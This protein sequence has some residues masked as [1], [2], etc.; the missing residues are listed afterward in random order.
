ML[1]K[2][3]TRFSGFPFHGPLG[4]Y[5]VGRAKRKP[6]RPFDAGFPLPRS[7]D[8]RSAPLLGRGWNSAGEQLCAFA[9]PGPGAE[10]HPPPVAGA[11]CGDPGRGW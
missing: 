5:A 8:L 11:L 10:E 9:A 2:G 4:G 3:V 6:L 1:L 7:G